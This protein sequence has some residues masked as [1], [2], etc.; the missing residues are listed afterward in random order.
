MPDGVCRDR[1][2]SRTNGKM[3]TVN[4]EQY[5]EALRRFP[6]VLAQLLSPGQLRL[7]WFMQVGAPPHTA[8]ETIDLLHQLFGNR[9]ISL[10]TVYE[11]VP[12]IPDLNPLDFFL[13][14][15]Y[16][17]SSLRQQSSNPGCLEAGGGGLLS[18]YHC[19]H[20]QTSCGE[21][22]SQ[23]QSPLKQRQSNTLKCQ[24]QAL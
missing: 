1:I 24:L 11:W 5:R 13:L 15:C 16:Q 14:G 22:R 12:H 8:Y 19:S 17:R 20:L 23:D 7:A 6:A 21:F 2:G 4:G 9:V 10:A 18:G 3:V